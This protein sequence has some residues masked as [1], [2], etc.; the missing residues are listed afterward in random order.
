MKNK[1]LEKQYCFNEREIFERITSLNEYIKNRKQ[2]SKID[3]FFKSN[4]TGK[5][6][7]KFDEY[8]TLESEKDSIIMREA[9]IYGVYFSNSI[10]NS[11]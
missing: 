6:Y 10:I 3:D 7:K 11:N 5:D 8:Q 2:S 9:F 1:N 4:L